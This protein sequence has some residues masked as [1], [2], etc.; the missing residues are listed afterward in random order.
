MAFNKTPQTVEDLAD[1]ALDGFEKL[2]DPVTFKAM[3]NVL[4]DLYATHPVMRRL[5]DEAL[6][7]ARPQRLESDEQMKPGMEDLEPKSTRKSDAQ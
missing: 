2:L 7:D 1:E 6:V 5:A 3:H 4:S